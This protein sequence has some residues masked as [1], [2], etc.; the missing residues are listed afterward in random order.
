[1]NVFVYTLGCRLNQCESE[2]ILSSFNISSFSIVKDYNKAEFIIVNTCTVTSKSEQKARRM[3]RLFS[4]SAVCVVVTGCYAETS[5]EEIISLGDN[6]VVFSLEEKPSLLNL[7]SYLIENNVKNDNLYSLILSFPKTKGSLFNFDSS[8]FIDHSRSYLKIQDGCD[9]AC[10]YCKTTIVRGQSV[11]LN[12]DEVIKRANRIYNNGYK[13]IVL[14]GVNLSHYNHKGGGLGPLLERLLKETPDGLYFRLSSLE[15]DGIDEK[16]LEE[17]KS[18][19]V[20]PHF[21][22]PLQSTSEKVLKIVNRHYSPEGVEEIISFLR[23]NRDD[24]FFSCDIITGLPGEGDEDFQNTYNF[25]KKN[26]FS[27][28]HIFPYSPRE[29]TPLFNY[30]LRVEERVRDERA[31]ILNTL[32]E[33]QYKKYLSRQLNKNVLV[34]SEKGGMGTTGNY[35]KVKIQSRSGKNINEGELYNGCII[36]IDP[37]IVEVE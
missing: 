19:R 8:S 37:L 13:E 25:L 11:F 14:T 33:E 6:I 35:L 18:P 21:H 26:D 34:V 31:K 28:M 7:P 22:I 17:L 32:K 10:G 15:P 23:K 12:A 36:N 30:P 2:S 3:I 29:G 9:N 4:K 16:L 20:M 1:M 24:P 27:S 5:R